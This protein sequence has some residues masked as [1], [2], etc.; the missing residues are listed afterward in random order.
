MR[1][2]T[3]W[4]KDKTGILMTFSEWETRDAETW[5]KNYAG[6]IAQP[7]N[8]LEGATLELREFET[9]AERHA[10]YLHEIAMHHEEQRAMWESVGD[11]DNASYHE[12]RRNVAL[13]GLDHAG[14]GD[15]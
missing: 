6:M 12:E 8:V 10:R 14:N 9:K 13:F 7:G 2:W 15:A 11:H 1:E 4:N 5:M 3:V